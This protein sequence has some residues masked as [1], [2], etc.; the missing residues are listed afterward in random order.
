MRFRF[1]TLLA[2][3]PSLFP[4]VASA[5]AAQ[6]Q[7]VPRLITVT[8]VF[9]PADGQ[10]PATVETVTLSVYADPQGGAPVFQETQQ[11]TLDMQ[12][13]YALLLG[14]TRPDGIPAEVFGGEAAHWLGTMFQRAGEVEGPR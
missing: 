1:A 5:Q 11:V 14:A 4:T 3:L 7:S 8:G 2:L 9:R 12:G 13:R 6:E 10:A